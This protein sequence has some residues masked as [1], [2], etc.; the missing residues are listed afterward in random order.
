LQSEEAI[1]AAEEVITHERANRKRLN[2]DIKKANAEL[3]ELVEKEKKTLS[4]K[5][6]AEVEKHLQQAVK[7]KMLAD[8]NLGKVKKQLEEKNKSYE[9]LEKFNKQ[10]QEEVKTAQKTD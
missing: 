9:E 7:E 1:K 6:L 10:M 2:A 5:V 8:E 3:R 4:D